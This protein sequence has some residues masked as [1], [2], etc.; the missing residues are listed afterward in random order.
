[1]RDKEI[2]ANRSATVMLESRSFANLNA[3][4]WEAQ[5]GAF[6]AQMVNRFG[7]EYS[8]D[9]ICRVAEVEFEIGLEIIN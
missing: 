8:S 4:D 1:M 6:I 2:L 5:K 7:W 3:R 9:M